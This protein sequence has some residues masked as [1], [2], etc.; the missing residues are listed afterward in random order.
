MREPYIVTTFISFGDEDSFSREIAA[1]GMDN[2]REQFNKL[3]RKGIYLYVGIWK[4]HESDKGLLEYE[5]YGEIDSWI[6]NDFLWEIEAYK[7]HGMDVKRKPF[8]ITCEE[9]YIAYEESDE[10]YYALS[11]D[12]WDV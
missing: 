8:F 11:G 5:E 9:N 10:R 7:K 1:F 12:P 6:R 3:V 4:A 2:A